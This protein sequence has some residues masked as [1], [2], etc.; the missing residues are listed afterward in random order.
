MA[1][2]DYHRHEY[3]PFQQRLLDAAAIARGSDEIPVIV[4]DRVFRWAKKAE[5]ADPEQRVMCV[6]LSDPRLQSQVEDAMKRGKTIFLQD[7]RGTVPVFLIPLLRGIFVRP[8]EGLQQGQLAVRI[9]S[10]HVQLSPEFRSYL[11]ANS[12]D[13]IGVL[14]PE[15]VDKVWSATNDEVRVLQLTASV[16]DDGT[17]AVSCWTLGGTELARVVTT[18]P[19]TLTEFVTNV[20]EAVRLEPFEFDLVFPNGES[21]TKLPWESRLTDLFFCLERGSPP[22]DDAPPRDGAVEGPLSFF[23][24]RKIQIPSTVIWI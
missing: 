8:Q 6:S 23:K 18:L 24:W 11:V 12:P 20:A 9:G 17:V 19:V 2:G 10:N 3:T 14:Q 15:L 4:E 7:F 22:H 13:D 1:P 16:R 21:S 5:E